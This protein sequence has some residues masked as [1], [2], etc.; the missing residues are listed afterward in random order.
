MAIKTEKNEGFSLVKVSDE[1]LDTMV[2]PDLKSEFVVLE[3]SGEDFVIVDLTDTKYCD[4]SG[5]SALLV[6]NRLLKDK[7][8]LILYGLQPN[9]RKLVEI[10]QLHTVLN[11]ADD[12]DTAKAMI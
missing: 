1:K 5:L 7:G 12:L 10:S 3:K 4:S 6:G 8:G 9:V 2:A 11:I